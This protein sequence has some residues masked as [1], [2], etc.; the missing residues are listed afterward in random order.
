L[1]NLTRN[2]PKPL[3][4]RNLWHWIYYMG[5]GGSAM[6]GAVESAQLGIVHGQSSS[7]SGDW[8]KTKVA[9]PDFGGF[10]SNLNQIWCDQQKM[11]IRSDLNRKL[12]HHERAFGNIMYMPDF[13]AT[14][15]EFKQAQ[16]H[17]YRVCQKKMKDQFPNMPAERQ[18][19]LL[20]LIYCALC[21]YREAI[22]PAIEGGTVRSLSLN[23]SQVQE[24]GR[25]MATGRCNR[26]ETRNWSRQWAPL[27]GLIMDEIKTVDN[28]CLAPIEAWLERYWENVRNERN[29]EAV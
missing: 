13:Q 19:A 2:L 5:T 29:R 3:T 14:E 8:S 21:H 20:D 6:S 18:A 15:L 26:I 12:K 27:W 1:T 9:N 23:T 25:L 28:L 17:L 11:Q 4:T 22:S 7:V 16:N 10:S 24:L